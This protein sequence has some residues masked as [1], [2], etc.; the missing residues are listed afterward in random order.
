MIGKKVIAIDVR[1]AAKKNRTGKGWY[2]FHILKNL[3]KQQQGNPHIHFILYS[4]EPLTD[5]SLP[6][7][8]E[9][10]IFTPGALTWHLKVLKD[11]KKTHPDLYVSPTSFIVPA[12]APKTLKTLITVHDLVAWLYPSNHQMKATLIERL[13]LPRAIKRT[14][15]ITTVSTN[16]KHDLQKLF[17]VPSEKITIIP[18]AADESFRPFSSEEKEKFKAAHDL[19][20]D[21]LLAVGTLE[22]R[23]NFQLIIE[24]FASLSEKFP[25]LHLI[26][27]GGKGWKYKHIFDTI[28]KFHL[29]KKVHFTGYV[30]SN[31]LPGY[32]NLARAFIFPSLYEGFGIPLLEA[33]KCG[34][35]VICSNTSSL[36]E[37]VEDAALLIDPHDTKSLSSAIEKLLLDENLAHTLREKGLRQSEKFS[38]PASASAI[39]SLLDTPKI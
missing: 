34:C 17:H 33:M 36:P 19:P 6:H 25:D 35:P 2:T 5:L 22:P 12:L 4:D 1:E 8:A 7:N 11:L 31:D 28:H 13:T 30:P 23:K 18:C 39:Y 20:D 21:F 16:T 9:L 14:A 37:V 10:K 29:Q 24:S 27:I 3:L 26:I 38:W 15:H 32:Y